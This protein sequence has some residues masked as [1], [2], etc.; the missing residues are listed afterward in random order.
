VTNSSLQ[1]QIDAATA[2]EEL[3]VPAEFQEWTPRVADAAQLGPGHRVLDVACGT[4]VLAREAATRVG[5]GGLVVG[6]DP[7]AGMLAVA[8][9]L[10]PELAWHEAPAEALP[11]PDRSFDAVVSQFGLMFFT[12]R[13][14]ALREMLRVLM[15]GGRL[16]IAVWDT[17]EATPAYAAEVAFLERMA[18]RQAADAVRAPFAL[19]DRNE[20]ARLLADAGAET[21]VI[22]THHGTARFPSVR[23]MVEA[24]LRGW[25]PAMGV[26]LSE[27]QIE[28]IL[29]E[30]EHALSAFVTPGGAV[31]FDS[32]A[33]IATA[34]RGA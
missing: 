12:D 11:F 31:A 20:L 14:Q 21:V 34:T 3:F 10:A 19:G 15:P 22:T 2:Y 8:R 30:A 6:L 16:A 17:L 1:A 26:V 13:H 29:E 32:P 4:G 5:A 9:R 23:V 27:D 24:E 25:L 7:H 18:G 33:H 28:R